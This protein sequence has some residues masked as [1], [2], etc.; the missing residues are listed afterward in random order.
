MEMSQKI[1]RG[2]EGEAGARA[3][4][5][6]R[7]DQSCQT[8]KPRNS[9]KIDQRRLRRAMPAPDRL[10]LR[11]VLG[12]PVGDPAAG[13]AGECGDGVV[14]SR[15]GCRM[16]RQRG[17]VRSSVL[18]GVGRGAAEG[19]RRGRAGASVRQRGTVAYAL[20]RNDRR[21]CRPVRARATSPATSSGAAPDRPR[22]RRP[23]RRSSR[24]RAGRWRR[25]RARRPDAA[26]RRPPRPATRGSAAEMKE[27]ATGRPSTAASRRPHGPAV[28]D[29]AGVASSRPRRARRGRSSRESGLGET[30]GQHAGEPR[31]RTEGA[32]DRDRRC[33]GR[34]RRLR[35][36]DV[37]VVAGR[38][39]RAATIAIVLLGLERRRGSAGT[40]GCCTSTKV[41]DTSTLA[42]SRLAATACDQRGDRA[43]A[44]RRREVPC[45]AATSDRAMAH[46]TDAARPSRR[47]PG[48][49]GGGRRR[50]STRPSRRS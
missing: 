1:S 13:A 8:T 2:G 14:A 27:T 42:R 26:H 49:R 10:P 3:A 46:A 15:S 24:V 22:P 4:G 32:G 28:R 33:S 47:V 18:R 35:E 48:A 6:P 23:A 20:R 31:I 41:P 38:E 21:R 40:S 43:A 36:V 9:A 5:P 39:Q 7:C 50:C 12:V 34:R 17:R 19:A 25:T 16:R 30:P 45:E 44:R 37:H 11:V 29:R